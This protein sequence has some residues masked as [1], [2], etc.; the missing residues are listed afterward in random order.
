M[1]SSSAESEGGGIFSK[2]EARERFAPL[3]LARSSRQ[4]ARAAHDLPQ[5]LVSLGGP[6]AVCTV[7]RRRGVAPHCCSNLPSAPCR[8]WLATDTAGNVC[9]IPSQCLWWVGAAD[10]W[11]GRSQRHEHPRRDQGSHGLSRAAGCSGQHRYGPF[12]CQQ[13]GMYLCQVQRGWPAARLGR[14]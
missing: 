11:L 7:S 8:C 2:C 5:S 14:V 4:S 3:R 6:F 9:I 12:G 13:A 10:G 1:I